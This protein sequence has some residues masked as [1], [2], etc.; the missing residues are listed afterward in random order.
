MSNWPATKARR[1]LAALLRLGWTVKR[2]S[3][4]HR[5]LAKP[6]CEFAFHDQDEVGPSMIARVAKYSGLNARTFDFRN[7]RVLRV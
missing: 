4:S 5:L 2:Q 1:L 7:Y 3:G 6:G